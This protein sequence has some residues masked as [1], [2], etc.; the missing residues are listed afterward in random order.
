MAFNISPSQF[1][2]VRDEMPN[3]VAAL[4]AQE[5]P[6]LPIFVAGHSLGG[7]LAQLAVYVEPEFLA[8][9]AFNTSQVNGWPWLRRVCGAKRC[10]DLPNGHPMCAA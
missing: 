7:S 2:H 5:G 8:A 4:K 9:Y 10:S 1:E 3:L 6:D